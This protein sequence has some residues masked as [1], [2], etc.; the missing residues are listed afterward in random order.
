MAER[1]FGRQ[2]TE[3]RRARA[4]ASPAETR[5]GVATGEC[6]G[7]KDGR[8]ASAGNPEQDDQR[9][10]RARRRNGAALWPAESSTLPQHA[11]HG[12]KRS[13]LPGLSGNGCVYRLCLM[14]KLYTQKQY[15]KYLNICIE[16]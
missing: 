9:V 3:V 13:L 12:P 14:P 16:Y 4:S 7:V 1:R 5:N 8:G 10:A 11:R 6:Q 15:I 2:Y